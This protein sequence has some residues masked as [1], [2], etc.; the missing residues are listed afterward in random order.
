MAEAE[1]PSAR[2][3]GAAKLMVMGEYAVLAPGAAAV[4]WGLTDWRIS[5]TATP[6]ESGRLRAKAWGGRPVGW[7]FS[8]AEVVVYGGEGARRA[9]RFGAAALAAAA[10][11]ARA[12]GVEP[13]PLEISMTGS[14]TA[15]DGHKYGI[16]SSS[17]ATVAVSRAA[18]G[19]WLGEPETSELALRVALWAHARASGGGSGADVAAAWAGGLARYVAPEP[20]WFRARALGSDWEADWLLEPWPALEIA[21]L[22][23]WPPGLALRVGDSGSS[24]DTRQ[25]I[26]RAREAEAQHPAVVAAFRAAS[27]E[28]VTAGALAL[29]AGDAGAWLAA[30]RAN[31]AALRRWAGA[32][33]LPYETPRLA[34]L[35]DAAEALGGAGKASG[36]GGGDVGL[37]WVPSGREAELTAAWE[38]AGVRALPFGS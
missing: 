1:G 31:R 7:E 22:P 8:G 25:A 35:A 6:V 11:V 9:W 28:A 13:G 38:A 5:A 30:I 16:G 10:A 17:A 4:V 24:A 36:A 21:P 12:R 23:G 19:A 18:L 33:A 34:A 20:G 26:A 29:A 37:A 14:F 3:T 32:L 27:A 2:G 15:P